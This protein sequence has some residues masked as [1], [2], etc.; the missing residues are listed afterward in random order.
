MFW[1]KRVDLEPVT[2]HP[3]GALSEAEKAR[4]AAGGRLPQ[5]QVLYRPPKKQQ[6]PER[7]AVVFLM[8]VDAKPQPSAAGAV[9][10]GGAAE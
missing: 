10:E 3:E 2:L 1:K 9:W 4:K 8:S 7:A 6:S 5:V